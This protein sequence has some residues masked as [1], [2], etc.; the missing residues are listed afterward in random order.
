MTTTTTSTAHSAPPEVSIEGRGQW[1]DIPVITLDLAG[2]AI[3]R[4]IVRRLAHSLFRAHRTMLLASVAAAT[5]G[6]AEQDRLIDEVLGYCQSRDVFQLDLDHDA[7]QALYDELGRALEIAET[8]C[9][10]SGC[11]AIGT[12]DGQCP[13]HT[14]RADVIRIGGAA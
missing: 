3:N 7:A 9:S 8:T 5:P 6:S 1:G 12:L 4:T 10:Q 13:D 2:G 11:E 14:D